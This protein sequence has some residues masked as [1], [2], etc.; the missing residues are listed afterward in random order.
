VLDAQ[1]VDDVGVGDGFGDV[2]GDAAAHLFEDFWD[3]GGGAAEGDFGAEFGEGPDVGAGDAA[4]EDVA[5]DGDVEAFDF[6]PLLANGED[7]E[8]RL[9]GMFVGAVAGVDDAGV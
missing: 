4:V 7:V 6:A 2:V 3:E 5:E 8:E 1:E 9:G